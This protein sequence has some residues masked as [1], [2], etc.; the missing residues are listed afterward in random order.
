MIARA[1]ERNPSN[2]CPTG[3]V[4]TVEVIIPML[5]PLVHYLDNHYG[6]TKFLLAQF[7]PSSAP[8]SDLTKKQKHDV[9]TAIGRSK[10]LEDACQGLGITI[11]EGEGEAIFNKIKA[12]IEALEKKDA[13]VWEE[14]TKAEEEGRV[15]DEQMTAESEVVSEPLQERPDPAGEVEGWE[16][17]VGQAQAERSATSSI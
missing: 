9:Q 8:I 3:P 1:A 2:F 14:R 7:H 10:T 13:T 4:G 12:R 6:N 16:V 17:G 5:I 11:K 15:V